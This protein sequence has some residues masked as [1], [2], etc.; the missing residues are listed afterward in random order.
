MIRVSGWKYILKLGI[1]LGLIKQARQ[2]PVLIPCWSLLYIWQVPY[3]LNVQSSWNTFFFF[4][5]SFK[6]QTMSRSFRMILKALKLSQS[7]KGFLS[8]F[9]FTKYLFYIRFFSFQCFFFVVFF[10]LFYKC[11]CYGVQSWIPATSSIAGL[12]GIAARL[13][14]RLERRSVFQFLQTYFF[15]VVSQWNWCWVS[16]L[17]AH[18][19]LNIATIEKLYINIKNRWK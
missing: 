4:S 14:D 8:F 19:Q 16:V 5:L 9:F 7:L 17:Q 11:H 10:P 2:E 12:V 15:K 1:L 13:E 6:S 18:L 3:F